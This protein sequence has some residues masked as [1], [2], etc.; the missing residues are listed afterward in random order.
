[1]SIDIAK[2]KKVFLDY[3]DNYDKANPRILLKVN[4]ILRVSALSKKIATEL[5]L[6]KEEIELAELIGLLHD[7]GRFEQ[8]KRYNTFI[9]RDSI[10]HGE[11]G[12]KILFEDGL[13]K[14]FLDTREYDKTIEKAII[15]HNRAEIEPNLDERTLLQCKIIRDSDKTDIYYTLLTD[16][17]ENTYETKDFKGMK[18]SKEME[19]DFFKYHNI[20][21]AHRKNPLDTAVC[22]LA[23]IFDYNFE[24]AKEIVRKN[25]Y[26]ETLIENLEIEDDETNQT[27]QEMYEE[28]KNNYL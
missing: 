25:K 14:D 1:M 21:Y 16:T 26:I 9:D 17:I 5:G 15:N 13:I 19:E 3:T 6:S 8:I 2:A 27:I 28:I 10:N 18:I 23:Y 12:A 22:H 11:F 20:N 24:C 4:H 7:I